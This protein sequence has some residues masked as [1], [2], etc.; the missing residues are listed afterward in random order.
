MLLRVLGAVRVQSVPPACTAQ[1]PVDQL[2]VFAPGADPRQSVPRTQRQVRLI[3]RTPTKKW[4]CRTCSC[5][6]ILWTTLKLYGAALGSS[7]VTLASPCRRCRLSQFP[8]VAIV[9]RLVVLRLLVALPPPA[10]ILL[11]VPGVILAVRAE[12]AALRNQVLWEP[13]GQARAAA[14][15][16]IMGAW[17]GLN[18]V[19]RFCRCCCMAYGKWV[20]RRRR[21]CCFMPLRRPK[22]HVVSMRKSARCSVCAAAREVEATGRACCL[23]RGLALFAHVPE[24]TFRTKSAGTRLIEFANWDATIRH[25]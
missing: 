8:L 4:P 24:V 7:I 12:P 9:L 5:R 21:V 6:R 16:I 20:C 15:A 11:L 2:A 1:L 25:G 18:G 23:G 19:G 10:I 3:R 13:I 14:A 17:L 22:P